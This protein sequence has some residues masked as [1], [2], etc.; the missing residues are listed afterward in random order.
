VVA[1]RVRAVF[2]VLNLKRVQKISRDADGRG[3][4]VVWGRTAGT[5]L[6]DGGAGGPPAACFSNG[7]M[8][9]C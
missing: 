6:I 1:R 4:A 7:K 2:H 9:H 8:T 3:D 5:A